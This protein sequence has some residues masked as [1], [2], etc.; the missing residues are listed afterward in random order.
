MPKIKAGIINVTGYIGAELAR[1]LCQHPRVKLVTVTGRSVAGQKLG[2]V[3]P[4]F[5]GTDYVIKAELD[6]EV[7]IAFSA[8][9]HKSSID[10]VPSL[11]KRGIRVI[12]ASADFRLKNAAEYPKWYGFTPLTQVTERSGFWLTRAAPK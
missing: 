10:I 12:D 8:M 3:F 2:D 1:L 11:L 9:P 7:D 5:A 6:G 4:S